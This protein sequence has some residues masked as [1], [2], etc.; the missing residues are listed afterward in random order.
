MYNGFLKVAAAS[1]K[2]KPAD[3]PYNVNEITELMARAEERGVKVLVFPEMSLCG[4]ST[5]DLV[6]HEL[7]LD[8]C[9]EGLG[10]IL[11]ESAFQDMLTLVGAPFWNEGKLYSAVFVLKNG[12]L[13]GIVPK[14][15][16]SDPE[17]R[18]FAKP[19]AG[20]IV[21][22]SGLVNGL[23]SGWD[24]D[25]DAEEEEETMQVPF[26]TDLVFEC[27]N[28]QGIVAA[29]EA[30]A[31]SLL[32]GGLS[33]RHAEEGAILHLCPA[34]FPALSGSREKNLAHYRA[35]SAGLH[36]AFV[37]A[38]AGCGESTTDLVYSGEAYVVED[39]RVLAQNAAFEDGL[40]VTDI[41]ISA[42]SALRMKNT[43][44]EDG[45][46]C[47]SVSFEYLDGFDAELDRKID[48]DPFLPA[49]AD[50]G[51]RLSE[52]IDIQAQALKKRLL[53][54]GAKRAVIGLSGGLDSTL[55]ILCTKRAFELMQKDPSD[56]LAVTMPAFGTTD[57][58]YNNA[59][60]LAKKC[61]A[62]LREINI[63]E[64][65]LRHLKDIGHDPEVRNAAYENAQ[66]R[67][68]TQILM[69]LANDV[70]G[71]VV[72]TGD[73]SELALG[74]CTYNGDHMS[75]Y[76]VNADIP[77]TQIRHVVRYYA[78]NR[79]DG[80]LRDVL[81]DILD[82]PV[83]PELLPAENG[84]IK[85]QT[86]DLV[87]PYELHDFFIY[88]TLKFGFAPSRILFLAEHAFAGSYDR[89]TIKKWLTTFFRRFF[90]QQFKRSC[91]PDGPKVNEVD[92]SPRGGLK[93]PSDAVSALWLSELEGL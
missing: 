70:N 48:R 53:H 43:A 81:L 67:E 47:L 89:E 19:G 44:A 76:A 57:R 45:P 11:E 23:R 30:G 83:S 73:L 9:M 59:C 86:E 65:V 63:S 27:A 4:V 52:I 40:I 69:D 35:L 34:A 54:T 85:Q 92:L 25:E 79:A 58:T 36:S 20:F 62:E 50:R 38:S 6:Q 93:F 66:A 10:A 12:E 37:V 28:D 21:A 13:L 51:A 3:V 17:Q 78:E 5:G 46:E 87:G 24:E 31:D 90:S 41:D 80:E 75:M 15:C 16:L 7:L 49:D 82:T 39:G 42:L 77:K 72:G 60:L 61:G 18:W 88:Y 22:D 33:V 84:K 26:G 55:A 32:P 8:A 29:V 56:I 1:P 64:S 68:R 91:S 2:V 71:A 14:K 74:W